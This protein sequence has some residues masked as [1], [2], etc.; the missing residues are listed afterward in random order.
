M[1]RAYTTPVGSPLYPQP[2]LVYRR[3]RWLLAFYRVESERVGGL[4]PPLL[5][6]ADESG[7]VLCCAFVADFPET[8]LG[9]YATCGVGV[10]V[11]FRETVGTYFP[12]VF[13]TSDAA[14]AAGREV[15]GTP[16]KLADRILFEWREGA[17]RGLALRGGA[18]LVRLEFQ[19]KRQVGPDEIPNLFPSIAYKLIPDGTGPRPVV[20]QLLTYTLEDTTIHETVEGEAT[21]RFGRHQAST[22]WR[23]APDSV[24]RAFYTVMSY[25]NGFGQLLYD[26]QG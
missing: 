2:P 19:G 17:G 5:E 15:W 3:T 20:E 18:E 14:M 1:V 12:D 7:G 22:M 24:E 6:P 9:P 21:L 11:R 16:K 26:Y 8:S 25:T 23:L 4:L 13:V 10:R